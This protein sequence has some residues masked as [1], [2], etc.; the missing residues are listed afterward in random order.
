MA[1]HSSTDDLVAI[2]QVRPEITGRLLRSLTN[3]GMVSVPVPVP[4][5]D[6]TRSPDLTS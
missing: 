6:G 3:R 4:G 5:S 1:D 2:E